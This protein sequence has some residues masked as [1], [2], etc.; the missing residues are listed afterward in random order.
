MAGLFIVLEGGEGSGKTTQ[1]RL[2]Y[3]RLLAEGH[4][5]LLLHEPGGTPLGEQVR[6]LLMAERGSHPGMEPVTELLLF[7]AAR[8]ELVSKVLRPALD[9]GRAVVCDRFT[10]STIA[11]QGYGRGIPLSTIHTLNR[12]ATGGLASDL[13]VLLD[14]PPEE[15][16]TR[17]S[18]QR[19][20]L[21]EGQ[22]EASGHS[23]RQDQ[24]GLRRFEQEPLA[25]QRK[26]RQG[27]LKQAKADPA[28]WL[29]VDGSLPSER[30]GEVVWER[31]KG[32]LSKA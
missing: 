6:R 26:V 19:S 8:A 12:L 15:A 10:P 2:L 9:G 16:L 29:V 23:G 24:E 28:R 11:Y 3:S 25:F 31:V 21:V 27:Y 14:I 20:L 18:A 32:L 7:S 5:P 1:A 17:V 22:G 30:I 13:T 4:A